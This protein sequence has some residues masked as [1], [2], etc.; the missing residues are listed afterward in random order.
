MRDDILKEIKAHVNSKARDAGDTLVI[1]AAAET[2]NETP[3]VVYNNGDNDL[4]D[5]VLAQLN[6]GA[7]IDLGKPAVTT[8]SAMNTNAAPPLSPP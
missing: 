1:D 3:V 8:P 2:V 4:T 7:P 6:A 5:A